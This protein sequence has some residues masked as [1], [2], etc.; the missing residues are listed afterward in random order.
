MIGLAE[1]C[2]RCG[3][4]E[5]RRDGYIQYPFPIYRCAACGYYEER[6]D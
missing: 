3:K 5:M 6:L 4:Y 1:K 2:P